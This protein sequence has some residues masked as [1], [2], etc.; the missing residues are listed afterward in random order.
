MKKFITI[1]LCTFLLTA[2]T[3]DKPVPEA[4]VVHI[5][6]LENNRIFKPETRHVS[7]MRKET[8]RILDVRQQVIGNDVYVE[9]MISDIRLNKQENSYGD[10][11]IELSVDGK[12]VDQFSTAAFIIKGLQRGKHNIKLD[13]KGMHGKRYHLS[14]EFKV[15]IE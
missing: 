7:A 8:E 1:A 5:V 4:L 13:L 6:M 12:K 3:N 14:K 2:C 15:T 10:G 9:C 11:Y